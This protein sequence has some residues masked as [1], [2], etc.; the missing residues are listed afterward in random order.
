[1]KVQKL[2]SGSYRIQ[3][4]DPLNPS[5]KISIVEATESKCIERAQQYRDMRG[6]LKHGVSSVSEA[7]VRREALKVGRTLTAKEI[8]EDYVGTFPPERRAAIQGTWARHFGPF[9][10]LNAFE[11]TAERMGK[12]EQWAGSR[13]IERMGG[14]KTQIGAATVKTAFALLR[15]AYMRKVKEKAIAAVPWEMWRPTGRFGAATRE[16]E[17]LRSVDEVA[18]LLHVAA[19]HDERLRLW[20]KYSDIWAR[21]AVLIFCGLRQ[22]ELG[23]LGWD[24]LRAVHGPE[25]HM[26][27]L[28][29]R[30]QVRA[31][32][33]HH[34]PDWTRPRDVP[35]RGSRGI[36][37]VHESCVRV[38]DEHRAYLISLGCYR[39]DGPI[40]PV[41]GTSNWRE[42]ETIV[43]PERMREL[44]RAT[45]LAIDVDRFMTHSTRHT[46]ATLEALGSGDL[47]A[48]AAR[49]RHAD[50]KQLMTY[51]HRAGRGLPPPAIPHIPMAAPS[52]AQVVEVEALPA[53]VDLL[54]LTSER[55]RELED[56]KR[57]ASALHTL[58]GPMLGA[59]GDVSPMEA[60]AAAASDFER[61]YQRWVEAGRRTK[62]PPEV[63]EGAEAAYSR[64][65]VAALRAS[66]AKSAAQQAGIRAKRAYLGAWG[67][68]ARRFGEP[69][70][71]DRPGV[72]RV[73]AAPVEAEVIPL[74]GPTRGR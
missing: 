4:R 43:K 2:P 29:V 35:K 12:W 69:P 14:Q 15:A 33:K 34:H 10:T 44:V 68:M 52:A 19:Q 36:M 72:R 59:S 16:R 56:A 5:K 65:Y 47:A 1:M 62:R 60:A 26:V 32:W 13:K 18:A 38:F 17:A 6:D 25:G 3:V 58:M 20:G 54:D 23:G 50:P 40:F 49:T 70:P 9:E 53:P 61:A 57:D 64:A 21:V 39:P 30:H 31:K 55:C 41:P 48:T 7:L 51:M 63:T 8:W 74:F 27:T 37:R 42:D 71:G 66:Q 11:L 24:D 45:G 28:S 46:F 73:E 22:G 67:R